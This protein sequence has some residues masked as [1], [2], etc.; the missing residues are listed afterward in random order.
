MNV[1]M[2]LVNRKRVLIIALLTAAVAV[3][4]ASVLWMTVKRP[5]QNRASE[6]N[7][8]ES[9][10]PAVAINTKDAV[11]KTDINPFAGRYVTYEG[12]TGLESTGNAF[13]VNPKDNDEDI[14]IEFVV[15]EDE[16]VLYSSDLVPSGQGL[17]VNFSE[18]LSTGDHDVIITMN[19]YVLYEGE[20]LRCPVNN[21]Q[22][23]RVSL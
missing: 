11:E 2:D 15:S 17:D 6:V 7:I 16:N 18:F 20:Y 1:I 12:I 14:Y 8:E 10:A 23:V 4:A 5:D 9:S 13:L 3:I 22:S 19:P 21:A